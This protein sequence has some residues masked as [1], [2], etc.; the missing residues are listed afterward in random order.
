MGKQTV[1]VFEILTSGQLLLAIFDNR[2][3][4]TN[5]RASEQLGN[6]LFHDIFSPQ[7]AYGL[8]AGIINHANAAVQVFLNALTQAKIEKVAAEVRP[9][10]DEDRQALAVFIHGLEEE[11]KGEGDDDATS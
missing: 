1:Y 4:D 9:M 2:L 8:G 10:T 6:A 3:L 5:K 7:Q 11:P